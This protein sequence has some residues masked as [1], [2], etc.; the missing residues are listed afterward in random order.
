MSHFYSKQNDKNVSIVYL[1]TQYGY[2]RISAIMSKQTL[3]IQNICPNNGI[4]GYII[5][6][7]IHFGEAILYESVCLL[8]SGVK[9]IKSDL[10]SED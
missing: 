2:G 8:L 5:R 4:I 7:G 6:R 1:S 9:G 3:F 10:I